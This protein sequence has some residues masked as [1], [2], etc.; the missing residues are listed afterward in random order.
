MVFRF[1]VREVVGHPGV[2]DSAHNGPVN[3]RPRIIGHRG[4]PAVFPEHTP[5][6]YRAA[7]AA[8]AD[9]VEPDV[10]P[11]RD[12]VLAVIHEPR[13]DDTT[14]IAS[15]PEFASR[16]TR[17]RA[18]RIAASGWFVEDF[19]WAELRTLRGIERWPALRPASAAH[20][21]EEGLLRLRD[22]VEL[23]SA[24]A[25]GVGLV[26]ELKH[27]ARTLRLGFDY[28][29][30]LRA[31]LDGLWDAPALAEL[32]WESFEVP[33]LQ[34]LRD[35][36]LPGK[37]IQLVEDGRGRLDEEEGPARLTAEGLAEVGEWANGISVRC[38]VLTRDL[39]DQAHALGLEVFA[40]TLRLE[41][42][43][44]PTAFAGDAAGWV[45]YLA[46]TGVDV[47]FADDPAAVRALLG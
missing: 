16:F 30:L 3:N 12:G 23:T 43:F 18:G 44:L 27:D 22:L 20:D 36:G 10:V 2:T 34:R 8:G 26:I 5:A 11:T 32:R 9:F 42:R 33:V 6:S 35:A 37:R 45:R 39:V 24:E 47:L 15:R 31:E 29:E 19:S 13:L 1:L 4:A 38:E 25:P 28:V 41:E 21:G 40:Y 46:D 17:K 14:D 7:F